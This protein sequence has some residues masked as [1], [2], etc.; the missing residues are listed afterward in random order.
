MEGGNAVEVVEE[1]GQIMDNRVTKVEELVV[2]EAARRRRGQEEAGRRWGGMEE[3]GVGRGTGVGGT[4]ESES[5]NPAVEDGER[6]GKEEVEVTPVGETQK[7][8]RGVAGKREPRGDP[9]GQEVRVGGAEEGW[10]GKWDAPN[11]TRGVGVEVGRCT[12][13]RCQTARRLL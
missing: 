10:G 1:G 6:I 13:H 9:G 4:G 7:L 11:P 8:V 12:H 2:G 3:G 5:L